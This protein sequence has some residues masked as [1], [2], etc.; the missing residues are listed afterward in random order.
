MLSPVREN[1][2][3][4]VSNEP[5]VWVARQR[6]AHR[7]Q[8]APG[9]PIVAVQERNNLS[10]ALR[11]SCVKRRCLPAVRF[12]QQA[13]LGLK[14]LYYFWR[15]VGR[16]IVHHENL[17]FGRWKV[18]FQHAYDR[19]LDKPLVVVGVDQYADKRHCQATTPLAGLT[20]TRVRYYQTSVGN[21]ARRNELMDN[22]VSRK[23]AG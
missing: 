16:T 23:N 10:A 14:L 3:D 20:C 6:F 11:N 4:A 22:R 19:L 8:L 17:P 21:S 15:T 1:F 9:P 7:R 18:L 13:H 5:D 12:A 2:R